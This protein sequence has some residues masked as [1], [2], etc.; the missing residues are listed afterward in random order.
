MPILVHRHSHSM[1]KACSFT[2]DKEDP[3]RV[4]LDEVGALLSDFALSV[5]C[6]LFVAGT[7]GTEPALLFAFLILGALFVM[8]L[9]LNLCRR[10]NNI[11]FNK[12]NIVNVPNLPLLRTR[13]TAGSY[14]CQSI[15]LLEYSWRSACIA[16]R[17]MRSQGNQEDLVAL[18]TCELSELDAESPSFKTSKLSAFT[19]LL[20]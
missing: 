11:K 3:G 20:P 4:I 5:P 16:C 7:L 13:I 12:I 14:V 10:K 17:L 1:S 2:F 15:L 19:A 8:H 18:Q 6:G 9:Q